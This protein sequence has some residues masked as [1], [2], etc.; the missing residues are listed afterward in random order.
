MNEKHE[1]IKIGNGDYHDRFQC[2]CCGRIVE[3][4]FH[5]RD[6]DYEFCPYCGE[7]MEV[8]TYGKE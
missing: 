5:K 3:L 6:C 2:P 8:K 1:W 7:P 4:A